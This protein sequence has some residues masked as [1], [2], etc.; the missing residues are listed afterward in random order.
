M[1]NLFYCLKNL[2]S[3]TTENLTPWDYVLPASINTKAKFASFNIDEATSHCYYSLCEGV[4]PSLRICDANPVYRSHGLCVDYDSDWDEESINEGLTSIPFAPAYWSKSFGNRVH[5]VWLFAEPVTVFNFDA[6][7]K[8]VTKLKAKLKLVKFLP[9]LDERILKDAKTYLEAGS[10]WQTSGEGENVHVLPSD[11]LTSVL[12]ESLAKASFRDASSPKIPLS[13]VEDAVHER[14]PGRWTGEFK[15]GSRGP[16]FWDVDADAPQAAVVKPEGM[17][18]Y[19]GQTAFMSWE[20]IFGSEFVERHTANR[21]GNA[22]S[23]VFWDGQWYW[24]HNELTKRYDRLSKED[25]SLQLEV[26]FKLSPFAEDGITSEVRQVIRKVQE[27]GRIDGAAPFV[28]RPFG[29]LELHGKRYLNVCNSSAMTPAEGVVDENDF[30]WLCNFFENLFDPPEQLEFFL[31]WLKIYYEG[32][33]YKKPTLGHV[34]FIAGD[35]NQ[36]KTLLSNKIIAGMIGNMQDASA[37]L[38]AET[39]FNKELFFSPLWT[40]DD[41]LPVADARRRTLYGGLIKK[42]AAN[43]FFEYHPKFE[44]ATMVEWMGRIIVTCNLDPES[45]R[46]IPSLDISLEDKVSAMR[47]RTMD[48]TSRGFH[49]DLETVIDRELPFFCRWLLD[50]K[51]PDHVMGEPRYKIKNYLQ[52]TLEQSSAASSETTQFLELI[53]IFAEAWFLQNPDEQIWIGTATRLF[54]AMAEEITTKSAVQK[55]SPDLLG[56]KLT[57]LASVNKIEYTQSRKFGRQWKIYRGILHDDNEED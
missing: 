21:V 15:E 47:I 36:G 30:P 43:R 40:M 41:T 38:T 14:F 51:I 48:A 1:T 35:V 37:Y 16:R 24:R 46:I 31:A 53:Q 4:N 52:E 39:N 18:C 9:G 49:Q 29:P 57:K 10:H 42:M 20:R 23:N 17:I 11:M 7:S 6:Y 5:A 55:Y 12:L 19:T 56:R 54:T 27:L 33:L 28:S 3:R 2:R 22:V 25:V 50:W 13:I 32:Q 45:I 26:D 44:N 8:F 34:M